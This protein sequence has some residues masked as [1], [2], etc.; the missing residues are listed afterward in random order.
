[1]KQLEDERTR[2]ARLEKA[3]REAIWNKKSIIVLKAQE[4][5]ASSDKQVEAYESRA[6]PLEIWRLLEFSNQII[7]EK[8]DQIQ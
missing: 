2:A 5:E 8:N 6:L 4:D 3:L 1:M 7:Q